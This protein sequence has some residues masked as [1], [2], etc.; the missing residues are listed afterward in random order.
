MTTSD[1]YKT[2]LDFATLKHQGQ[3]RIGG[4]PYITHPMAVASYLKEEG[5]NIDYQIA[6][7]FHDLLEDTDATPED[8]EALGGSEVLEAVK[9]VTKQKGFI[10][11]DYIAAIKSNPMASAVKAADR[12]HNLRSAFVA[13]TNF[14]QKYVL[15]SIDWYLDFSPEIPKAVK[16]LAQTLKKPIRDLSLAYTPLETEEER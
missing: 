12:L 2:A 9:L 8:I 14:R 3:Y 10:M 5:Y 6:G 1:K 15:E 13:D 4:E 16:A 11:A 7:L